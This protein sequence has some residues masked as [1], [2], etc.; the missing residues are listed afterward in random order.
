MG[1]FTKHRVAVS[2]LVFL[3]A[4][5]M[6]APTQAETRLDVAKRS[7]GEMAKL[8]AGTYSNAEAV[9]FD[10]LLEDVSPADKARALSLI[11]T[12]A[13]DGGFDLSWTGENALAVSRIA[14][15][16]NEDGTIGARLSGPEESCETSFHPLDGGYISDGDCA[17]HHVGAGGI[18]LRGPARTGLLARARNFSCWLSVP[19]ADESGWTFHP[20]LDLP[21]QGK[22]IWVE[23]ETAM[24]QRVGLKLRRVAWPFGR[25]R[26]SLV[27]YVHSVDG[28]RAD[29][30]AWT[31][32]D[33]DRIAINLR[34]MQ[35]SCTLGH[36]E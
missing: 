35:A 15:S 29:S 22:M 26:D 7:M 1:H 36:T 21:D 32:Y 19:K 20:N 25:N 4:A 2:G 24:T 11:I 23:D 16:P 12:E 33:S 34:W 5:G 9:Y 10:G 28:S 27:L 31:G 30:Y 6:L 18:S 14:L 17:I 8:L 3:A 13:A